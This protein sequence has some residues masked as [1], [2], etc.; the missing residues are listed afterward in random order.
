VVAQEERSCFGFYT[1][2]SACR[3]GKCKLTTQ[4]KAL[5]NSD[6]LDTASDVLEELLE[7]APDRKYI[8]VE[9]ASA[10]LAQIL[11]PELLA[12]L[13]ESKQASPSSIPWSTQNALGN[14]PKQDP[15]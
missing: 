4:C 11:N 10:Q 14:V 7:S 9:S 13:G 12:G 6:I 8:L 15:F 3:S 1:G 2:D 5:A